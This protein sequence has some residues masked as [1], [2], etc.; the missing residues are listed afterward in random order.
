MNVCGFYFDNFSTLIAGDDADYEPKK[1]QERGYF[2]QFQF[3]NAILMGLHRLK[4]I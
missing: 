3:E 4:Y 2:S 1:V